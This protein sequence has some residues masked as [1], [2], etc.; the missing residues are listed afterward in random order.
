MPAFRRVDPQRAGPTALGI[1]V[2]LGSKTLVI[3]RPR[4][5]EWDLLPARWG[6]D[7]RAAPVFCQFSR[8]EAALVARRF[9][10]C[11]EETVLAGKDP[12]ETFGDPVGQEFQVWVR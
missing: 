7:A 4:G 6:G 8:E 9:Q 12:V 11:L 3:L 5:L 10:Q 1:L 2:P